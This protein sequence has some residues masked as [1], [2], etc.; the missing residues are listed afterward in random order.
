MRKVAGLL[1]I[2]SLVVALFFL[3]YP[4]YVVRPFRHQGVTELAVSLWMLRYRTVVMV[5]CVVAGAAATFQ[6]RRVLPAIG[7][8]AIILAAVLSRIN[9]YEKMFH[10]MGK[11]S[12]EAAQQSK[13]DGREMVIAVN[14]G[15]EARAYPIRIISYHHIAND[16]VGGVP[17]VATY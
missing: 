9:V 8:A 10:P 3:I 14:I 4:M 1:L 16:T 15:G 2:A 13:L 12:M 5:L 17:I 11:P 6:L 7:L